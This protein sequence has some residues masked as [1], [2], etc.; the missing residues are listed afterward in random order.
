[1]WAR[2]LILAVSQTGN[3]RVLMYV[4]AVVPDPV[5]VYR[6]RLGVRHG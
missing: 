5:P 2:Q 6:P 4:N 3:R 1:M